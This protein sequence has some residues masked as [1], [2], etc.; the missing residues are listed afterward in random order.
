MLLYF[1][2]YIIALCVAN[3][4]T[5]A[6]T[7][8]YCRFDRWGCEV[9]AFSRSAS[10]KEEALSFGAHHFVVTSNEEE[11]VAA[12]NSVDIIL[13]TAGGAGVDWSMLF[14]FLTMRGHIYCMGITGAAIPVPP[15][16]LITQEKGISGVLV[17]SRYETRQM[18]DF[19]AKHAIVPQIE[20][21]PA[22]QVNEV[23]AKM[24]RSEVRY[25]AVLDFQKTT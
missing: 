9:T 4:I 1:N 16:P 10:K 22:D 15:I 12:Y 20:M 14:N 6:V 19:A 2:A 3:T 17:G 25:R 7:Q 18:L 24:S 13:M 8:S 5:L 21:F 23:F 11:V